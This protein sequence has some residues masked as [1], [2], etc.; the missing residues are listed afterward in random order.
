MN[1][2]DKAFNLL[3]ERLAYFQGR[4]SAQPVTDCKRNHGHKSNQG[5]KHQ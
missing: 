4:A 3:V 1:E 2:R 5:A